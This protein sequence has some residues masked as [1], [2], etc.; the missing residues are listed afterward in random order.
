MV[1]VYEDWKQ[2]VG[3]YCDDAAIYWK[4]AQPKDEEKLRSE[5]SEDA[6][7]WQFFRSLEALNHLSPWA[8]SF[9]ALNDVFRLYYWQRLHDAHAIDPDIDDCLSEFEPIHRR[10]NRQHTETDLILR[11]RNTLV[12]TEVKLGYRDREISGWHQAK[13]SPIVPPYEHPARRLMKQPGDWK[14]NLREFAQLYKNLMLGHCLAPKWSSGKSP[15]DVHL[16]VIVNGATVEQKE[17]GTSWTYRDEFEVFRSG[18]SLPN[19]HLHFITWQELRQW[20]CD[21]QNPALNFVRERL[22]SHPLL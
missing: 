22:C 8:S 12:M 4:A 10:S 17:D 7:T 1:R 21:E 18:C 16:L 14:S 19:D 20:T 15:L 3:V 13:G 5:N 6:L 2:N 9:L 11:G